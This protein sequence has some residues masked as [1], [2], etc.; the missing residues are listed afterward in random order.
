MRTVKHE[1]QNHTYFTNNPGNGVFETVESKNLQIKIIDVNGQEVSFRK[2][3]DFVD[4]SNFTA[5]V[6][7]VGVGSKNTIYIKS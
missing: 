7:L 6:Y 5:G 1:L 4:I 3:G 2:S